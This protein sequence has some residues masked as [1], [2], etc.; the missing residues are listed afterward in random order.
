MHAFAR[1]KKKTALWEQFRKRYMPNRTFENVV[2][3]GDRLVRVPDGIPDLDKVR[4]LSFGLGLGEVRKDRFEPLHSLAM[5]LSPEDFANCELLYAESEKA[6]DYLSG[7][8][9]KPETAG[10]GYCLVCVD[11]YSTGFG[12]CDGNTIKNHYPKGLRIAR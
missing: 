9:I 5:A 4:V 6:T 3:V 11:G 12:K 1:D 2:T 10:K 7:M 8:E